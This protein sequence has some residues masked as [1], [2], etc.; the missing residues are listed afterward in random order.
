MNEGVVEKRKSISIPGR[1][2]SQLKNAGYGIYN[3]S[4]VEVCHWTKKSLKNEG[5]C[6]KNIFYGIDTHRCVQFSPAGMM[7]EMKC[8][9][10]WRPMEF[11]KKMHMEADEVDDPEE[12]MEGILRERRRLLSG[13]PG[14]PKTNMRK[15]KESLTPTHYAI[16]LSGEP[17]LY[18][19]LPQLV[20]Y[21][22]TLPY[23]KSIFIVTNGLEPDMLERLIKED[24]LPTQLYLSCSAPN[25]ELFQWITKSLYKDGWDRW[26]KSL[27]LLSQMP[28]RTVIRM[29]MI[30]DLNSDEEYIDEYAGLIR[31]G[32]PHFIE[33]KSYMHI[34]MSIKRLKKSNMLTHEE[35]KQY[36]L[37][38]LDRLDGY[39]LMDEAPRSRVVVLQNRTRYVD[40][41]I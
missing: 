26:M 15:Y 9:F 28:T 21:L 14:N 16:S 17:T 32:N 22:K 19:K 39:I 24:A 2:K 41:W 31:I 25:P 18:P 12:L 5:E 11:M 27:R 23:T 33:V 10:C 40:R 8:I 34:G 6:Y 13:Y 38:L 7:C 20:K 30:K 29:T 36:S 37:K 4:T 1:I 35:I 3:H